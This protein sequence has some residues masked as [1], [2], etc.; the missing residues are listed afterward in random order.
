LIIEEEEDKG[1]YYADL[2]NSRCQV[3]DLLLF[4]DWLNEDNEEGINSFINRNGV[5][6]LM[7]HLAK[8]SEESM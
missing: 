3:S 2:L 8:A 6:I 7:A 1:E 4:Y 5:H